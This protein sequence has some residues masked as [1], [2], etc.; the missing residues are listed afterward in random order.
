[1]SGVIVVGDAATA[2]AGTSGAVS[3]AGTSGGAA[4]GPVGGPGG[5]AGHDS[6]VDD[7]AG[8]MEPLL[9]VAI[10]ALVG[11]SWGRRSRGSPCAG[12]RRGPQDHLAG[13]A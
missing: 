2:A 12:G 5:R 13:I 1:M 6:R 11:W 7:H 3:A 8:G 10:S 4:V 9:L